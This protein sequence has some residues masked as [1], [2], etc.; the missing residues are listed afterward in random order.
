MNIKYFFI[1]FSFCS[2]GSFKDYQNW[3][4]GVFVWGHTHTLFSELA[5]ISVNSCSSFNFR[6]YTVD[7]ML[8][9]VQTENFRDCPCKQTCSFLEWRTVSHSQ[10]S[11][12]TFQ[13]VLLT[14]Q[15]Q[16]SSSPESL[17]RVKMDYW[18][19]NW[20]GYVPKDLEELIQLGMCTLR[21]Y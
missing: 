5:K 1:S 16:I 2:F 17:K 3:R 13:T 20:H 15:K 19:L 12:E 7:K 9:I 4:L 18:L 11:P 14:I 8:M 10:N 6:T 21:N